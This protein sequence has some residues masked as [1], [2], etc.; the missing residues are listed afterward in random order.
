MN[1][2]NPSPQGS[3]LL[4]ILLAMAL[5]AGPARSAANTA[6][7]GTGAGPNVTVTDNGD[8]TVTMANG[9]AA[10]VI[11]KKTG[12]LN[13]VAYTYSH[14][15]TTKTCETLS[16]KGQYYYGGFSLGNGVF[17]YSLATDPAGNGGNYADIQLLSSTEKNGIMEIHFSMLRGS[18][19]FYSTATMTHRKQDERFE[20]GAWGVV[21]RVPPSFN[22]LSS[23]EKRNWFIGVPTKA[24]VKVPDSPHEITVCLDGTQAGNY[25]DKFI[26][27][28][29]H[30]DLRAWGWQGPAGCGWKLL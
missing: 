27:G 13:S 9:I 5:A 11:V 16:G 7:D 17:E 4:L 20:V 8:D 25:A 24:G 14:D 6:P 23:D 18:P 10:I 30:S 26:Y 3:L 19:G 12:R 15:E 1:K 2:S 21:T 22:W 29:D 28:Q